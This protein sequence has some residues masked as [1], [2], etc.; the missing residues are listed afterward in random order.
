MKYDREIFKQSLLVLVEPKPIK[1][2]GPQIRTQLRLASLDTQA[3]P[4]PPFW[5]LLGMVNNRVLRKYW[6]RVIE[7]ARARGRDIY[8]KYTRHGESC[9]ISCC[10]SRVG[11]K[12]SC[13]KCANDSSII[14][15]N[16]TKPQK[17]R[18]RPKLYSHLEEQRGE[19]WMN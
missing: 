1:K 2:Y 10:S 9:P 8:E 11:I 15:N 6:D 17:K 5:G 19:E 18:G 12:R 14:N 13:S 16:N 3:K 7:D 4:P